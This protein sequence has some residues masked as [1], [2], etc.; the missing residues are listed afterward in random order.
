MY[1][2]KYTKVHP[3]L[4]LESEKHLKSNHKYTDD[5]QQMINCFS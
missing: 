3:E 5:K 2:I 4:K 1:T